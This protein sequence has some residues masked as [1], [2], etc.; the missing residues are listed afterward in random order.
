MRRLLPAVAAVVALLAAG[1]DGGQ[2]GGG[3]A[4]LDP[5]APTA[6]IPGD[7]V[8]DWTTYHGDP[9]RT[10]VRPAGP[11]GTPALAWHA[12]LDG[13][14]YGQPLVVGGR[15]LA[16]TE[17][18]S[19]YSLDLTSGKVLWR[20]HVG[21]PVAQRTLPCGNIDPLGITGTTVYDPATGLV[22]AVAETTG[23]HHLF[24]GVDVKTGAVRINRDI[25][26][27]DGQPRV[28]QQRAALLLAN[29]RVYVAFGGLAGDCGPYVGS[30]VGVPTSGDGPMISYR[31]PTG[32]EGGIWQPGGPVLG[33]D[34]T[35]FVSVGNGD[36]TNP[37]DPYD[38]TDSV[39]ALSPDLHRTGWFAPTTWAEDNAGDQDLGS[40]APAVLANGRVFIAGK[41]GTGYLLR[42]AKLGGLGHEITQRA[43]CRA[44]GGSAVSGST[45]YVPC[46][47]GGPAAVSLAGD[48]IKVRWRG[49]AD[50][51]GSPVLA[52]GTLWVPSVSRGVLYALDAT[53]G[54]T[55]QQVVL[56]GALPHFASPTLAGGTVL[57]GTM[58]G[59]VAVASR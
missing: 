38:G 14:V 34:G 20:S 39:L 9:G 44:F 42:A 23:N 19:I 47:D 5:A 37:S 55:T 28:N 27:P 24:I 58:H 43:V 26:T 49:P 59:V 53:T 56:G 4:T 50:A 25:P 16:A 51:D 54:R 41:R 35:I 46:G 13:A 45:V 32:R 8:P 57:V 36:A 21:T 10:G 11:T 2:G 3:P 12:D 7:P 33:P 40:M 6:T 15:V 17:N 48:K 30:V 18:D 52:G 22:F 29:G 31:V 1:C